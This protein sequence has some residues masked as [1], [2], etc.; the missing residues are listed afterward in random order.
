MK[1]QELTEASKTFVVKTVQGR[2]ISTRELPLSRAVSLKIATPAEKQKIQKLTP[3]QSMCIMFA[4]GGEL[5]TMTL[6]RK[7]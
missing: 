3:N 4:Q 5:C 7:T 2:Q 1:I 6:T